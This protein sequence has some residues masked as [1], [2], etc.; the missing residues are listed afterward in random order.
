[1]NELDNPIKGG[2][3]EFGLKIIQLY[4]LYMTIFLENRITEANSRS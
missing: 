4:V 3:C 1:M 2:D